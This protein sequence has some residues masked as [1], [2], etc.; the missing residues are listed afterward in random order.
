MPRSTIKTG[1]D[2][3]F[4]MADYNMTQRNSTQTLSNHFRMEAEQ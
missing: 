3:I 2:F 1:F 4:A